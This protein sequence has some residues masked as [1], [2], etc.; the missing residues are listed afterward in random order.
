M[1]SIDW[2][3]KIIQVCSNSCRYRYSSG[4]VCFI[5]L[6]VRLVHPGWSRHF[7]SPPTSLSFLRL[8]FFS[9]FL[10]STPPRSFPYRPR[11][12]HL[13]STTTAGEF[14]F[15]VPLGTNC[16]LPCLSFLST[17]LISLRDLC[18]HELRGAYSPRKTYS[19]WHC[20]LRYGCLCFFEIISKRF[21]TD[22]R[23]S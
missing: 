13:L 5:Y 16:C 3:I 10:L 9:S 8:P 7:L 6:P 15:C 14:F 4:L 2:L 22:P 17:S 18:T 19:S 11:P 23:G 20:S 1:R 12:L 21:K